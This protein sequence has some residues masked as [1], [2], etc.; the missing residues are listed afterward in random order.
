[1]S[2]EPTL[3]I[4]RDGGKPL[5]RKVSF[6]AARLAAIMPPTTKRQVQVYDARTPGLAYVVTATN[7][8]SYWLVRR[9]G[10]RSIRYRIGDG[11]LPVDDVRRIAMD[12]LA[13]LAAGEDITATRRES[14]VVSTLTNAFED[15]ATRA[16]GKVKS[17]GYYRKTF[18]GYCTPLANRPVHDISRADVERLHAK[19]GREHGE[20]IANRALAV[21]S[22]VFNAAAVPVNPCR[23]VKRFREHSRERFLLPEELPR[24]VQAVEDEPDPAW[25]DA[26]RLLLHT[27]ARRSNV[28]AMRWEDIDLDAGRWVIP[29]YQA[30]AGRMINVPLNADAVAVLRDRQ[31]K[32]DSS[33]FVFPSYGKTGHLTEI[34]AAWSRLLARA[35][36]TNL[37]RHDVRRT[38]GSFMAMAGASDRMIGGALGQTSQ[39]AVSV[40]ARFR[41]ADAADAIAAGR[42]LM[43]DLLAKEQAKQAS[44]STPPVTRE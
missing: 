37:T 6:T 28:L 43:L 39:R 38:L 30:K 19:I 23:G 44:N 1:M 11:S 31:A 40:Y 22:I 9:V 13:R 25:R 41:T 27:G 24:F 7:A 18:E 35:G 33:G 8:R 10:V 3:R 32:R 21:L 42:Q 20:V 4:A 14:R 15:Y 34:K 16:Q 5:A 29:A 26:F 12:L 2:S 36:L 17:L